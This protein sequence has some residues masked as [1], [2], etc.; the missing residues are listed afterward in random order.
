MRKIQCLTYPRS[1][2]HLLVNILA[3]YFGDVPNFDSRSIET[4]KDR[5][6]FS[7]G[8]FAYCEY[9]THCRKTPCIN[10]DTN[11]QKS[12]DFN[13]TVPVK[14]NQFYV[15]QYRAPY[16][17][18]ISGFILA[19]EVLK[20]VDDSEKSWKAYL[21]RNYVRYKRFYKKWV[22][23]QENELCY[24][25]KYEE[26]V[27][28]PFD[29]ACEVIEFI[30]SSSLIDRAKLRAIIENANIFHNKNS[31]KLFKYYDK[32]TAEELSGEIV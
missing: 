9:Y 25:L 18:I 1:G 7:A 28:N 24:I 5:S 22:L 14:P 23:E 26:L 30:D 29:R 13:S 19:S 32:Q 3:R 31:E 21:E 6:H 4:G 16:P 17:A 2:H 11:F 12:H 27:Q 8:K 15:V 10:L 20:S